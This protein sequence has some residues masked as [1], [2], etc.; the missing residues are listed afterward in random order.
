MDEISAQNTITRFIRIHHVIG[1]NSSKMSIT[2]DQRPMGTCPF[3]V[4]HTSS[5]STLCI[6]IELQSDLT[7]ASVPSSEV[8][9][10]VNVVKMIEILIVCDSS[11]K[12]MK[13]STL[14]YELFLIK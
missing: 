2:L 12:E 11:P 8:V 10:V 1:K 14:Y 5:G 4:F 7:V 3:G 9:N 13:S 6:D